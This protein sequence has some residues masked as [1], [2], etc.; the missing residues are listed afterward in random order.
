MNQIELKILHTLANLNPMR[1]EDDWIKCCIV[2]E[3]MVCY[4]SATDII[5]Y[6]RI[7]EPHYSNE[8]ITLGTCDMK[9]AIST[10][11]LYGL[12]FRNVDS[13]FRNNKLRLQGYVYLDKIT[14]EQ[15]DWL[16]NNSNYIIGL[17]DNKFKLEIRAKNI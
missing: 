5:H 16:T 2:D 3:Y 11:D 17:E 10:I 8:I 13:D 1:F 6:R 7:D 9:Q 15:L 14:L 4:K 12:A